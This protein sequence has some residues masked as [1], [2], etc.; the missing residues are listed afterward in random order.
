MPSSLTRVFSRTLG[1]SPCLPVSVLVRTHTSLLE[2]FLGSVVHVTS[3]PP[4]I[5]LP[6]GSQPCRVGIFLHS[7]LPPS[8]HTSNR[9][10]TLPSALLHPQTTVCGIGIFADCPSHTLLRLCLGSDLPRGDERCPGNLR[11]SVLK[12]SHFSFRYSYR[13]SHFLPV[14]DSLRYRF[15]QVRTLPYR[16]LLFPPLRFCALAP[17]I[18]GAA[19]LDQ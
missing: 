17:I 18:F 12:V 8:T 6:I 19:S 3:T 15:V 10:L 2:A 7:S 14:H 11:L 13:H 5:C 4:K 9:A 16:T 1:C